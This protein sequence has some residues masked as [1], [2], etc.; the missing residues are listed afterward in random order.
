MQIKLLF[1][2]EILLDLMDIT[3]AFNRKSI[4][5]ILAYLLDCE[6]YKAKQIDIISSTGLS[7]SLVSQDLKRLREL[8]IIVDCDEQ[9]KYKR[10][11]MV[12]TIYEKYINTIVYFHNIR[13]PKI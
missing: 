10:V 6:D 9:K 5:I 11:R 12:Y 3:A 13:K 4:H 7:E 1:E 2:E 8:G